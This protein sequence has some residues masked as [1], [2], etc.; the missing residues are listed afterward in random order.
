MR[1]VVC[2]PAP[3][4][5]ASVSPCGDVDGGAFIPSVVELPDPGAPISLANA[6]TY[7]SASFILVVTCWLIGIGLGMFVTLIKEA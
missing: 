2:I 6:G 1:V 7:F 4:G 3:E 5:S